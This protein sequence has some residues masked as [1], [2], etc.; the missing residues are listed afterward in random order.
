M[1]VLNFPEWARCLVYEKVLETTI[2]AW[3]CPRCDYKTY[4]ITGYEDP[5]LHAANPTESHDHRE[6][7]PPPT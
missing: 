3:K 6:L 7:S 1:G 2:T 5:C 4:H